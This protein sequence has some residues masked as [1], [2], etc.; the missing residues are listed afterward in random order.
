[1]CGGGCLAAD[2]SRIGIAVLGA[3]AGRKGGVDVYASG[4]ARALG[5]FG[6][7]HQYTALTASD[8]FD[9]TCGIEDLSR[10][11]IVSKTDTMLW[12]LGLRNGTS[13]VIEFKL[14]RAIERACRKHGLDVVHFP[15]TRIPAPRMKA[16]TILTFFD[17]QYAFL[18]QFFSKDEAA[19]IDKSYRESVGKAE[20][21]IAPTRFTMDSLREK[22]GVPANK[23]ALISAGIGDSLGPAKKE[24]IEQVRGKYGLTG[25]YIIYPAN[26]WPHKNHE[27]LLKAMKLLLDSNVPVPR[28]VLTGRLPGK[29]DILQDLV[30]EL[31]VAE[32]VSDLGYVSK[33][34]V[35]V[36]ISG[37]VLLV[38][39]SLFEGFGYPVLEAMACGCPVASA[40]STCLPELVGDAGLLFDP[41]TPES[42]ANAIDRLVVRR[43]GI[44]SCVR[45]GLGRADMYRWSKL[46]PALEDVYSHVVVNE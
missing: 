37:A 45:K 12:H 9:C 29:E 34:D 15:A 42:I 8:E 5:T 19:A 21:I 23:M 43:D 36:L 24:E 3:S 16:R 18:P 31:G 40:N 14:T 33:R 26:P 28:L 38:F 20:R 25:P 6:K 39:P 13:S 1:M 7:K 44:E 46:V 41:G 22:Y 17:M 32:H 4:L 11:S 27:K 35:E 2:M 10:E 30:R